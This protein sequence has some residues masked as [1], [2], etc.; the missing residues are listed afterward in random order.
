MLGD[1]ETIYAVFNKKQCIMLKSPLSF[2]PKTALNEKVV[3]ESSDKTK[4]E[5]PNDDMEVDKSRKKSK[6][7]EDHDHLTL[8]HKTPIASYA[9]VDISNFK[10]I[11]KY[12]NTLI[13]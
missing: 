4:R 7:N 11:K 5:L 8:K 10:T 6:L 2:I 13:F 12:F 3:Q 9:K 1:V